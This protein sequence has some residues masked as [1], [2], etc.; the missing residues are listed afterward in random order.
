MTPISDSMRGNLK[1]GAISGLAAALEYCAGGACAGGGTGGS[2]LAA[3]AAEATIMATGSS[4]FRWPKAIGTA[5]PC[6]GDGVAQ[7][8]SC[9]LF[10]HGDGVPQYSGARPS[11]EAS[12]V[13]M[14]A[15]ASATAAE[16]ISAPFIM[17]DAFAINGELRLD[18]PA[19]DGVC[20]STATAAALTKLLTKSSPQ[21]FC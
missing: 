5:E 21:G 20:I 2:R 19:R 1:G 3:A 15:A 8:N 12:T 11:G 18:A 13:A 7:Q 10:C 16:T 14:L 9:R 6:H 4:A 17:G